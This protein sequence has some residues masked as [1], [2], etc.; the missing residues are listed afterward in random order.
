MQPITKRELKQLIR[1]CLNEGW[2]PPEEGLGDFE[3][4]I[5]AKW[6]KWYKYFYAYFTKHGLKP[7]DQS[8][9]EIAYKK[10]LRAGG[11][12]ENGEEGEERGMF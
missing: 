6:C 8:T 3:A 4:N 12:D 2:R 9:Y 5:L 10:A 11:Y 1:E 7:F